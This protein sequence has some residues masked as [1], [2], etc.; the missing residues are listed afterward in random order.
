M[1]L[2]VE[3]LEFS[4]KG[5]IFAETPVMVGVTAIE[6]PSILSVAAMRPAFSNVIMRKCWTGGFLAFGRLEIVIA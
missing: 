4:Q 2:K 3:M 5:L 6:V 1:A